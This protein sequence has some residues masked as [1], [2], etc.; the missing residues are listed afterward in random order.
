MLPQAEPA[1]PAPA[2]VQLTAVFAVPRTCATNCWDEPTVT[3]TL[4]GVT[5]TEIGITTVTAAEPDL[6]RSAC[7]VAVT[8]T[9]GGMGTIAG[10]EY[11]PAALMVPQVTPAHPVPVTVQVTVVFK[12]P[13]TFAVN[14]CVVPGATCTDE[15]ETETPISAESVT[16]AEADLVGSACDVAVTE[17]RDGLGTAGGAVYKP[18][19]VI[20]PQLEPAQPTPPTLHVT[21]VL[22]EPVTVAWNCFCAP[23]TSCALVGAI[24][25]PTAMPEPRVTAAE[26]VLVGSTTR[27][28]VTVTVGGFGALAGAV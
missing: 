7:E 13:V 27:V 14:G 5:A 17:T 22:A 23:V 24:V 25:I 4:A 28:A 9:V 2:S 1:H 16:V 6:L 10:A 26:A 19:V 8:V 20:V 11:R 21:A 12:V 15:G 3:P 18:P